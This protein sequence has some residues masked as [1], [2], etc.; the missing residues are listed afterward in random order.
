MAYQVLLIWPKPTVKFYLLPH[1]SLRRWPSL[2]L[3][4]GGCPPSFPWLTLT[5]QISP[6][7]SFPLGLLHWAPIPAWVCLL[8]SP[9]EH[10][11]NCIIIAYLL[12]IISTVY[13]IPC[14]QANQCPTWLLT[15]ESGQ[16]QD[17]R[18]TQKMCGMNQ[19]LTLILNLTALWP[20]ID[21]LILVSESQVPIRKT[22]VIPTL[23]LLWVLNEM[24]CESTC[25]RAGCTTGFRNVF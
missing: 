21:C 3:P 10:S 4:G 23:R 7:I 25:H 20:R 19:L 15:H 24:T 18:E 16:S 14:C 13:S 6:L 2:P 9:L 8:W 17:S 5:P 1:P 22:D 11:L 12:V